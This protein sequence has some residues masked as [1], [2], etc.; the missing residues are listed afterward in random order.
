[1]TDLSQTIAPK[2]D[3]LNSD[4]LISGPRT[5]RITK[6]SAW[7]SEQPIAI[8]FEGDNGKPYLPCKSMRRVLVQVW[9]SDGNSFAGR[10]MTLYRD[11]DVQFG[12]LKVGGIRISHMSNMEADMVMSLTASKKARAPFKVKVLREDPKPAAKPSASAAT[13]PDYLAIAKANARRGK[14]A[15]VKWWN[16]AEGKDGRALGLTVTDEIKQIIAKA[17]EAIADDPFGL[18]PITDDTTLTPEQLAQQEAALAA[19]R[20]QQ[21]AAGGQE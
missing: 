17:E 14:D 2:S 16:S 8:H 12:G 10:A 18:P 6:V 3:Q 5:I 21:Q 4:D 19:F 13:G 11:P 15:F 20:A 9:G 7:N 1:M